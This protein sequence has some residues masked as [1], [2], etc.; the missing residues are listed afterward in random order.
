MS[1]LEESFTTPTTLTSW[2]PIAPHPVLQATNPP[3][4]SDLILASWPRPS[5]LRILSVSTAPAELSLQT[6]GLASSA[7]NLKPGSGLATYPTHTTSSPSMMQDLT[8]PWPD[9]PWPRTVVQRMF[10]ELGSRERTAG[11]WRLEL[12]CQSPTPA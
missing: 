10:P 5:R 7:T 6:A 12:L 11:A 8:A 4:G 3:A 1:R 9:W 2:P